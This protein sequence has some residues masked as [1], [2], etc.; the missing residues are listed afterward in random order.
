MEKILYS[1]AIGSLMYAQVCS[2]P[3]IT[4]SISVLSRYLS[5]SGWSHWKSAKKVMRYLQGTKNY[6]LTYERSSN[7]EVI[8][9]SDSDFTGCVDDKKS[10]FDYIFMMSGGA[11]SWKKYVACY[12][13][14]CQA[15]WLKKL[16]S[17]MF[18]IESI[19]R[20]LTIYCD[21]ALAVCFSQN[22]RNFS[23]PNHFDVKFLFVREKI[24]ESHTRIEH[25]T[26]DRMIAD[27][28]TKSLPISVFQKHVGH[29]GVLKSFDD[30][31]V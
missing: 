24:H 12:E 30:A 26:T 1:C 28:L 31:L 5:N 8:G 2:R 14:T 4:F 9:Y 11:V 16:I 6:M 18:V 17:G 19:S 7:L 3:D 22:H 27:P 29:M 23:R 25:I 20:P 21:N 15:I 10:T 13:A